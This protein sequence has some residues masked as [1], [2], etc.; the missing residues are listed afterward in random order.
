M[1]SFEVYMIHFPAKTE[2]HQQHA[3]ADWSAAFK[4]RL[5]NDCG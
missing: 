2:K 1:I 5:Y 4:E 3:T